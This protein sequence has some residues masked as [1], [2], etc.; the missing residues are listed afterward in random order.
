MTDSVEARKSGIIIGDI[1]DGDCVPIVG[2]TLVN[3]YASSVF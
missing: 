3:I 2:P 1:P